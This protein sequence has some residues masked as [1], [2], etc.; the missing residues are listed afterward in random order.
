MLQNNIHVIGDKF[1]GFATHKN[2]YT[3]CEFIAEA[4]K[5]EVINQVL[6]PSGVAFKN[7]IL[8]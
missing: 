6:L 3:Y 4:A 1:I 8:C 7:C 5:T 2:A